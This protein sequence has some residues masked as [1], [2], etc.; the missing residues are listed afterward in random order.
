M[1]RGFLFAAGVL[2][3]LGSVG[4]SAAA[5]VPQEPALTASTLDG[6]TFSLS[7]LRGHVV[8]VHFWATWCTA[9]REEMPVL[10]A[11][12]QRYRDRGVDVIG[13]S[14]DRGRDIAQV[15]DVMKAFKFPVAL[16]RDAK[17]NDFGAQNELPV[18]YVI[19]TQGRVHD[20]LRPDVTPLTDANLTRIV[21]P[22]LP[23][24]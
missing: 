22:L 20:S 10:D 23:A 11:F 6:S 9:C 5:A 2:W 8:L 12:Y 18:T 3:A 17:R 16:V 13:I 19:D 21:V 15:R 24:K 1:R 14:V 4:L 7:A